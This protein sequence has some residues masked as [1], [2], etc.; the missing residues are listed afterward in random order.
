MPKVQDILEIENI[1][2]T[3]RDKALLWFLA[4]APFRI[5]TLIRLKWGDLKPTGEPDV[6]YYLL[7]GSERLKGKGVGKCKGVKQVGFIH[8]LAAKKLDAYKKSLAE[9]TT[10]T[11]TTT[12]SSSPSDTTLQP[13]DLGR[14]RC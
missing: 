8:S 9:K 5:S 14:Q 11:V 10:T 12:L 1:F 3:L 6:P 4:S 2:P 13:R 7:I